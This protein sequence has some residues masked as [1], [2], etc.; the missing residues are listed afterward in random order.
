LNAGAAKR[1]ASIFMNSNNDDRVSDVRICVP[2]CAKTFGELER[3][4]ERAASVADII[5]FRLDCLDEQELINAH[6]KISRVI[7]QLPVPVIITFRPSEEG[8][9]RD[10]SFEQRHQFWERLEPI[11]AFF[12]IEED[13]CSSREFKLKQDWARVICSHHDFDAVPQEIDDLYERLAMTPAGILKIAAYANDTAECLPVFKL[14]NRAANEDRKLIALA[15]DDGGLCT[16]ILGP[17]RG[18]FLTYGTLEE[19]TGTAPGQVTAERMK[20]V[21]RISKIS[22]QTQIFGL[23]GSPVMHSI[24]P[25]IHNSAF[26]AK[27]I[28]AVYLPLE[29]KDLRSFM[30]R[31]AHPSSR[32]LDWPLMGL[33]VTAPHKLDVMRYLDSVETQAQEIG[34]VN[35]VVVDGEAM[36]GYNTDVVGFIEPLSAA[37][38]IEPGLRV[39][40]LGA[41]GAANAA[42]WSLK[43]KDA[44]VVLFA[45]D[46]HKGR[47]LAERFGAACESLNSASFAGF[48]VVVNATP[49]GSSGTR[50]NETAAIADQLRGVQLAYDLVY[51]PIET[52]F[53]REAKDAGCKTLGGLDMLVAQAKLQF[54]LWTG[55]DAPGS[56]MS[57]A[58]LRGLRNQ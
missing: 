25:D 34:A 31:M 39:A 41:G 27:G 33:S 20:S 26:E 48:D 5:E 13:L 43:Q 12:D 14:L 24:S 35:T 11:N 50:A 4:T 54:K 44:D 36:R 8:G 21:Y 10:I 1:I 22:K 55:Q 57:A 2:L 46:V 40:V 17:S 56:V 6:E 18:S 45:R 16:R 9:Y 42:V 53:M 32:E 29:V 23:V 3:L 30:N 15:M 52:R 49:L 37:I 47:A 51:N 19:G 28:D 38:N 58:A 7:Q